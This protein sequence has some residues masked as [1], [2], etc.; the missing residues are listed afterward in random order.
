MPQAGMKASSVML[1]DGWQLPE[2]DAPPVLRTTVSIDAAKSI[3]SRN[4]SPDLPFDQSI[5]P[6]KGCEHGCIYYYA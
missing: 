3:I 6:Y 1:D 4:A 5:N 2:D